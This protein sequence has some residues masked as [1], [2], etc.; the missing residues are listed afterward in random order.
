MN[1]TMKTWLCAEAGVGRLP[2]EKFTVQAKTRAEA[3]ELAAIYNATV[4]KE[5]Q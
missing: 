4:I 1:K 3:A 2:T 5:E